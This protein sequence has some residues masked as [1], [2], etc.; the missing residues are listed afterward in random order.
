MIKKLVAFLL[1]IIATPLSAMELP[2]QLEGF[3]I[4]HYLIEQPTLIQKRMEGNSLDLSRLKLNSLDGLADIPDIQNITQLD[5]KDNRLTLIS[6]DAFYAVPQL[7]SLNLENNSIAK[8][9]PLAFNRLTNLEK[10]KLNDNKLTQ[11]TVAFG[12]LKNLRKLDL[13]SNMIIQISSH[14]FRDQKNLIKLDLSNNDLMF[15]ELDVFKPL[16]NLEYL[17]ISANVFK[18][19]PRYKKAILDLIAEDAKL[20]I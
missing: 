16:K 5:L 3:S 10:L 11:L 8:L 1:I 17:D 13:S 9:E 14:A 2:A 20:I 19:I 4:R 7:K 6:N 15:V 12:Q 18:P